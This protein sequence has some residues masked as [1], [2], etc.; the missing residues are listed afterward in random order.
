VWEEGETLGGGEDW[1]GVRLEEGWG[2]QYIWKKKGE[3]GV[4]YI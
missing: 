2:V 1:R 3:K 4:E